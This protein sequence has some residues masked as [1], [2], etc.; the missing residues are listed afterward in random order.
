MGSEDGSESQLPINSSAGYTFPLKFGDAERSFD[1]L[2]GYF[3]LTGAGLGAGS[4][5]SQIPLPVPAKDAKEMVQTYL[6]LRTLYIFFTETLP[7]AASKLSVPRVALS[8]PPPANNPSA[9]IIPIAPL[10]L[11]PSYID[12][13]QS[14]RY[15]LHFSQARQP[16]LQSHQLSPS[17]TPN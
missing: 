3:P 11:T 16:T 12:L 10:L 14:L 13:I 4:P 2:V 7:P 8:L 9:P 17:M 15:H 1:G 6:D 5:T